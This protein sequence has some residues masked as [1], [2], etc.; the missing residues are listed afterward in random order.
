VTAATHNQE[1]SIPGSVDQDL[2]WMAW[3][4][5]R[6]HWIGGNADTIDGIWRI[7]SAVADKFTAIPDTDLRPLGT[8]PRV[9][10]LNGPA[11]QIGLVKRPFQS[12]NRRWRAV[13][14]HNNPT[15]HGG[16]SGLG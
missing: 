12:P 5:P 3:N 11:D 14:S 2:Y 9:Y 1:I 6:R 16:A 13:Y 8:L 7:C 10:H 4:S 15:T